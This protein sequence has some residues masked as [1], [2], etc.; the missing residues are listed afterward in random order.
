MTNCYRFIVCAIIGLLGL[1]SCGHH[2]DDDAQ[3]IDQ[4][5]I[6]FYSYTELG[7][8]IRED[9]REMKAAITNTIDAG[10]YR[11]LVYDAL[12]T[13]APQIYEILSGENSELVTKTLKTYSEVDV[14]SEGY[15]TNVF[16]DI[17]RLS[18]TD[19]YKL[20]GGGHGSGWLPSDI[21]YGQIKRS[22]GALKEG[23]RI[24]VSTFSAALSKAEMHLDL[25]IFDYCL[26]SNI[27]TMWELRDNADYI[28]AM[29][30]EQVGDGFYYTD[31]WTDIT[32]PVTVERL[33]NICQKQL[34]YCYNCYE[35]R[36]Y[37]YCDEDYRYVAPVT[38]AAVRCSELEGV[39]NAMRDINQTTEPLTANP[40]MI[41]LQ[42]YDMKKPGLFYDLLSYARVLI[43]DKY[44]T[45]DR[46]L[47]LVSAVNNAVPVTRDSGYFLANGSH[48]YKI[49]GTCCLLATSE[50]SLN[51]DIIDR[52]KATSW[53][54]ATH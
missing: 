35:G 31:I 38:L 21:H 17:K 51:P 22:F 11:V 39:A 30:G 8:E 36:Q 9:L 43:G 1:T 47:R 2:H 23:F 13:A 27:E 7:A 26:M 42:R 52:K 33:E 46:Y 53:W 34:D 37:Y 16:R 19:S 10:N 40:D 3:K 48:A 25:I 4:T 41:G 45:D 44:S 14:T 49:N 54:K 28:I 32:A 24:D 5:I 12:N 20:I 15:L 29:P 50:P 6:I 18:P